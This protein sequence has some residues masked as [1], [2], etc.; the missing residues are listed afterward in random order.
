MKYYDMDAVAEVVSP[1]THMVLDACQEQLGLISNPTP[2]LLFTKTKF[3]G[4]A[5][6]GHLYGV[7]PYI[8]MVIGLPV[9]DAAIIRGGIKQFLEALCHESIHVKQLLDGRLVEMEN[10][11]KWEGKEWSIAEIE[12]AV[13]RMSDGT[14]ATQMIKAGGADKEAYEKYRSFP[15]EEEAYRLGPQ[16]DQKVRQILE[17][18]LEKKAA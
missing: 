17:Q 1:I 11:I 8:G 9:L 4:A 14:T 15:W 12:A 13:G 6:K 10:M 16:L 3:A 18:K 2:L 7:K 5:T